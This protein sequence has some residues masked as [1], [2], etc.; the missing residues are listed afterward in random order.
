MK[1]INNKLKELR[2]QNNLKQEEVAIWLSIQGACRIS[3]WE[4]GLA[5]P[6]VGNLFKL[7]KIYKVLPHVI[8]PELFREEELLTD[9]RV[10]EMIHTDQQVS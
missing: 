10:Q 8:Y 5:M 1:T 7:A 2:L 6:S 4:R 3:K 9:Q